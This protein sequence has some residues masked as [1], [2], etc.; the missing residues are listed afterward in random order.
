MATLQHPKQKNVFKLVFK[1]KK[2][3]DQKKKCRSSFFLIWMASWEGFQF[4]TRTFPC[5]YGQFYL[6]SPKAERKGAGEWWET[7]SSVWTASLQHIPPLLRQPSAASVWSVLKELHTWLVLSVH[8]PHLSWQL[9][10]AYTAF[11]VICF[12]SQILGL[13][14]VCSHLL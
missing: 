13:Q 1:L 11:A 12:S 3:L 8:S 9:H 2:Y 5:W 6:L 10:L 4:L 7:R 14:R